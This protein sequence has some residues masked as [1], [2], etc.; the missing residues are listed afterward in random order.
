MRGQVGSVG[1]RSSG[2]QLGS[3]DGI[4]LRL[5]PRPSVLSN[6]MFEIF[7][8]LRHVAARAVDDSRGKEADVV[9]QGFVRCN[10]STPGPSDFQQRLEK[11]EYTTQSRNH[12][13]FGLNEASI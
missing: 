6:G 3:R 10:D 9:V 4:R 1:G 2:D 5:Q 7:V 8:L 12:R 13:G 11:P